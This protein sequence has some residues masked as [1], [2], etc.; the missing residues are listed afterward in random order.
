[1]LAFSFAPR[2]HAQSALFWIGYSITWASAAT[3]NLAA[4][5]STAG[6]NDQFSQTNLTT[7]L[8]G[9]TDHDV[10]CFDPLEHSLPP[11]IDDDC[12]VVINEIILRL[13]D[14]PFKVE[15]FGYSNSADVDLS[16]SRNHHWDHG[17]CVVT[18]GSTR[19][20]EEDQF[21]FVDVAI[22]AQA[23]IARCVTGTKDALGGHAFIGALDKHFF[24]IVGG[25]KTIRI[26]EFGTSTGLSL[27]FNHTNDIVG[28]DSRSLEPEPMASLNNSTDLMSTGIPGLNIAC[29]KPGMPVAGK[30]NHNDCLTATDRLLGLPDILIP[31]DFTTEET[32][33]V[34]V[35][36]VHQSNYCYLTINTSSILSKSATFP[37]I[38]VAYYASEI[39]RRCP[40]G[41]VAKL[42]PGPY[43][44]Y[45]SLTGSSPIYEQS[46]LDE[47]LYSANLGL[48]AGKNLLL[49][50]TDLS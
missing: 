34:Q 11:T 12:D 35:P 47:L 26:D 38:K 6:T 44:F 15:T 5:A 7:N 33:G 25:T 1:M 32:G 50:K 41:G 40:I 8:R 39:M 13:N 16:L 36:D 21:R 29:T 46:K 31:Q 49:K 37:Y 19:R 4:R 22:V 24:V 48:A 45:V 14:D 28:D 43:G 27:P 20:Y 9:S 30:I 23:I 18:V 10:E 42:T 17:Q 3:V 2:R